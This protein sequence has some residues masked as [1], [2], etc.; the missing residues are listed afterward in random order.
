MA[1]EAKVLGIGGV[2]I[3]S[4]DPAA[5]SAWYKRVLGLEVSDWGGATFPPLQRGKTVW[6]PFATDTT[7]FEPSTREVMINFVV[8]DLDALVAKVEAE[9]VALIGREDADAYGRFAW[10]MDPDGAKVELWEPKA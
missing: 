8:E 5:L 3:K 10:L 4:P 7:H 6:T 2:F 9:G 1:G